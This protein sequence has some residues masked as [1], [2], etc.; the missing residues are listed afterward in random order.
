MEDLHPSIWVYN[1]G[2]DRLCFIRNVYKERF[3][4]LVKFFKNLRNRLVISQKDKERNAIRLNF[5]R[6]KRLVILNFLRNLCNTTLKSYWWLL[7][8]SESYKISSS[9][10]YLW[11]INV[12]SQNF[13]NFPLLSFWNKERLCFFQRILRNEI[14]ERLSK[15]QKPQLV[16]I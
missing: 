7:L 12:I 2:P 8:D 15:F 5:L 1:G 13:N 16:E 9:T 6:N 3:S 14:K 4:W 11:I 10:M